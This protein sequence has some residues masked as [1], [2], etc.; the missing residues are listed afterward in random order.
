[1][2][3]SLVTFN[4]SQKLLIVFVGKQLQRGASYHSVI[5][6]TK[7]SLQSVF[8]EHIRNYH[9]SKYASGSNKFGLVLRILDL[10]PAFHGV[11]FEFTF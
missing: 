3:T 10:K 11:F 6:E 7:A 1:M 4:I 9:N 2:L 5:K 8:V